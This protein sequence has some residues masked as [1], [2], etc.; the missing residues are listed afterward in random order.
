MKRR[1]FITLSA[2]FAFFAVGCENGDGGK[3][4]TFK[5]YEF[6]AVDLAVNLGEDFEQYRTANAEYIIESK[7]SANKFVIGG[8]IVTDTD[9]YNVNIAVTKNRYGT[10]ESIVATPEEKKRSKALAEYFLRNHD[11][12]NLGL[13]QGANWRQ[14]SNGNVTAGVLQTVEE[15]EAKLGSGLTGLTV[16]AIFA[17]ISGRSYAVVTM[18]NELFKFSLVNSFYRIDFDVLPA[19]LGDN[20]SK[21]QSDNRFTSYK[22]GFGTLNYVWFYY[23]LDLHD[24]V[25]NVSAYADEQKLLIKTIRLTMPEDTVDEHLAAWKEYAAGDKTL[26]LGEFQKA[27]LADSTGAELSP[28]ASQQAAIEYV[29]T[30]G[31]PDDF[32]NNVVVEYKK[33]GANIVITLDS[34]YVTIDIF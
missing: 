14:L 32:D 5:R 28:L 16:D 31:R 24:N 29:E 2:L 10:V 23:A 30:N 18:E 25:F 17:I 1:L 13:W 21:L 19:L 15:T 3:A 7:S 8:I 9:K 33:D 34:K 12:E 22:L 26:S 20:W 6:D 11:V 4:E 27:Y